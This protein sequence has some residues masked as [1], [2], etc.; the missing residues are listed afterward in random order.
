VTGLEVGPSALA[1][2]ADG[3]AFWRGDVDVVRSA[4]TRLEV[5]LD[6]EPVVRGT[7]TDPAGAPAVGA[8]VRWG[9]DDSTAR[10]RFFRVEVLT[11]ADGTFRLGG[12]PVGGVSMR[13]EFERRHVRERLAL[14][15]GAVADWNPALASGPKVFG[16][17][18]GREGEP[19][20]GWDVAGWCRAYR[21]SDDNRVN[22]AKTAADG[23]FELPA[24]TG[25]DHRGAGSGA[26]R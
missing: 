7:V 24:G 25:R 2:R 16:R 18:T 23:R 20:A 6:P 22:W 1:I 19:L 26:P 3:C 21:P 15:P 4:P 9:V 12:L 17:L 11:G 8:R 14:A 5:R 13:A 10:S